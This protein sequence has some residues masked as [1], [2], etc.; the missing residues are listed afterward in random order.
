MAR[1]LRRFLVIEVATLT[2][3]AF[4]LTWLGIVGAAV[5]AALVTGVAIF[6]HSFLAIGGFVIAPGHVPGAEAKTRSPFADL[7]FVAR[8][9]LVFQWLMVLIQPFERFWLGEER[10]GRPGPG[11][12]PAL[13]IHGYAC[14]RGAWWWMRSRLRARGLT[15]ATVDLEPP[16]GDIDVHAD[17]LHHRIEALCAE[18]RADRVALICHSMGGLAARAYL[19]RHGSRRVAKLVT[20]ATPHHGTWLAHLGLGRDARQMQPGNPWLA[21]LKLPRADLPTLAIWSPVDNFVAPQESA[22]L[23]GA[24][25]IM[26]ARI[27]HL[28]MLFSPAILAVLAKELA[29]QC[30]APDDGPPP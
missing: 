24:R 21:A 26:L 9:W 23:E 15:V 22:R 18:T 19:G 25:E 10:V 7:G 14:N 27:G 20:L 29:S 1:L 13:L 28:S 12:V 2:S 5:A 17:E 11:E 3:C 30:A 16:F 6:A 4:L 8:E